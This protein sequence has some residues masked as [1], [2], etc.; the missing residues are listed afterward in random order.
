MINRS[1]TL[2]DNLGDAA[3]ARMVGYREA[4]AFLG[5]AVGTLYAWVHHGRVP[6]YRLGRRCVRFDLTQ[7]A[8]W[9]ALHASGDAGQDAG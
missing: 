4:A 7:L 6:C 5:V 1:E 2:H 8:R 9:L 3:A